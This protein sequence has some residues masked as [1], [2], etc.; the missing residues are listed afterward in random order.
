[1]PVNHLAPLQRYARM[2]GV[3]AILGVC[4]LIVDVV[5]GPI[6]RLLPGGA[7]AA[8]LPPGVLMLSVG[9]WERRRVLRAL[10]RLRSGTPAGVQPSPPPD[11]T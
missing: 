2:L 9:L 1:M 11:A 3:M 5:L 6:A 4:L 8:L 7:T 10:D